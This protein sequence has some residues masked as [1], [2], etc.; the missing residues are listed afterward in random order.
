MKLYASPSIPI[1]VNQHEQ[2]IPVDIALRHVS[3]SNQTNSNDGIMITYATV[4]NVPASAV[5]LP[6]PDARQLEATPETR[7]LLAM[8]GAGV[9]HTSPFWLSALP[10]PQ[11]AWVLVVQGLTP[12]GLDWREASRADVCAALRAL[13]LRLAGF[14]N[15]KD[16]CTT[17]DLV[18]SVAHRTW[19]KRQPIPVIAIGHSNGGQ[20]SLQLASLFP[21]CIPALIP[22]AGYTSARLYVSTQHSRGSLFADAALQGIMKASVQGQDGD[23][24]A[25]N[26]VLSRGML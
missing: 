23:I 13:V 12:W 11:A 8:H 9:M 4:S 15:E 2:M 22:A 5:I 24:V 26:L 14:W 19:A 6:P 21:D 3:L 10:R 16:Y 17:H 1:D 20:G 7:I 18:E 25:G